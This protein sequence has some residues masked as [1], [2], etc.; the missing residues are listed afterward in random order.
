MEK[1]KFVTR[2]Q[3]IDDGWKFEKGVGPYEIWW[4]EGVHI[5]W[6][7]SDGFIHLVLHY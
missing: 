6:Q 4:K 5:Y 7:W 2:Q 1:G 3:L